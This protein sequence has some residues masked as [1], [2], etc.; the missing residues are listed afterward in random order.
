MNKIFPNYIITPKTQAILPANQ[1]EY[2]TIVIEQGRELFINRPATTLIEDSCL[3]YGSTYDGRR[4]SVIE[5]TNFKRKTPIPIS[6]HSSIYAFPT[7]SPADKNCTWIFS[8]HIESL[9]SIKNAPNPITQINLTKS[10]TL[11]IPVSPS[12]IQTQIK[13]TNLC[14]YLYEA[15]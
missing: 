11:A 14:Q 13:R 12:T 6:I 1:I 8:N 5:R 15:R 2:D 9:Q 3:Y 7:H 4:Q 10:K